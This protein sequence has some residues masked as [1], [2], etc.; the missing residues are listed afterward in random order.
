[1]S[2]ALNKLSA[3]KRIIRYEKAEFFEAFPQN[4]C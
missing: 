1:M 4:L 3:L 2:S